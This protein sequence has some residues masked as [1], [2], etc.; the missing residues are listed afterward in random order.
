MVRGADHLAIYAD[1]LSTIDATL[2]FLQC[3]ASVSY[4]SFHLHRWCISVSTLTVWCTTYGDELK[5]GHRHFGT[6]VVTVGKG[7][8]AGY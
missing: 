8:E 3:S 4:L 7:W 6:S 5:V 2:S 1:T